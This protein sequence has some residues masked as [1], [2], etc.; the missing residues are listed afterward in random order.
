[1]SI[2][3]VA[4]MCCD[5]SGCNAR[6]FPWD[7]LKGHECYVCRAHYCREHMPE[8]CIT[9]TIHDEDFGHPVMSMCKT[10]VDTLKRCASSETADVFA[11]L[12][13][14]LYLLVG[15]VARGEGG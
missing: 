10:C 5:H 3:Q 4:V 14:T 8:L 12:R 13:A 6:W 11:K 1:M 7:K 9:L 2:E 15:S